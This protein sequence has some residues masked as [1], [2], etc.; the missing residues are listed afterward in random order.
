[1]K[2][3]FAKFLKLVC[4]VSPHEK[5]NKLSEMEDNLSLPDLTSEGVSK[6]L[7]PID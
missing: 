3:L 2:V 5:L 1:M 6:T 4:L 7:L